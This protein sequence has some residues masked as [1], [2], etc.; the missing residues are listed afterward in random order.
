V[1]IKYLLT[2]PPAMVHDLWGSRPPGWKSL[3]QTVNWM[4]AI[5][6][7]CGQQLLCQ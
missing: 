4:R 3:V 1:Y 6:V 7:S 2:T 5:D